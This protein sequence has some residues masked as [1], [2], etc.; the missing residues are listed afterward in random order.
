MYARCYYYPPVYKELTLGLDFLIFDCLRYEN[1]GF[2]CIVPKNYFNGKKS[3]Y[4]NIYYNNNIDEKTI[5]YENGPFQAILPDNNHIIIIIIII[6]QYNISYFTLIIFLIFIL[7]WK[8]LL[9]I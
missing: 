2:L 4:Y 8:T 6:I 7:I 1:K 9:I 3:W 5:F